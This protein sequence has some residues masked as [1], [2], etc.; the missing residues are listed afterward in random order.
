MAAVTGALVVA[1]VITACHGLYSMGAVNDMFSDTAGR[2]SRKLELAGILKGA[3]S[4]MA[5]AQRGMVLFTYA[6]DPGRVAVAEQLFQD[7][8]AR[9]QQALAEMRPLLVTEAGKQVASRMEASA[10]LWLTAIADVKRLAQSGD[11]DGAVKLLNERITALCQ[12]TGKDVEELTRLSD[13]VLQ[14]QRKDADGEFATARWIMLLLLVAGFA[15]GAASLAFTRSVTLQLRRCANDILE[16][17]RQMAS[18][19][20]QVASASQSLAQGTSEQAATLE[21]TSSS[22]TEIAAITR[23]NAQNTKSVAGLMGDTAKLVTGANRNLEE[24]VQ[25]MKEINGS[26]AKISKIIQVIDEIAFQTNILA[27]NAAVEAARAGEAGMG[28]AV[29]ADEVRNL[30]Q[31]SAQA[32]KDTALLIEESIGKSNEGSTRLNAVADSIRQIT[33]SSTQVKT[34]VDEVN[35]GSQE[36]SRGIEQITSAVGQMDQVTQRSAANA[37]QSAAAG[38]ELAA[39]SRHLQEVA[40]RLQTLVG[41]AGEETRTR[42]PAARKGDGPANSAGIAALG[43]SLRRESGVE[44]NAPARV[45]PSK[46]E[47]PLD[48]EEELF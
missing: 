23:Q 11:A 45:A 12:S 16:G 42:R 5:V 9:F 3:E 4:D 21:E 26:S 7:G 30:A 38:E 33:G 32:A 17:S 6:K 36:Q 43:K 40:K 22:A 46:G 13:G 47:F 15:I 14:Q 25:S 48:G 8:S 24:M 34:L 39:Q 44:H 10:G 27:L 37:E 18:A 19:A 2:T 20:R 41:G 1:L 35:A 29:V 31:R 28:F